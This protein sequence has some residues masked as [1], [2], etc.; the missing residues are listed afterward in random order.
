MKNMKNEKNELRQKVIAKLK[1]VISTVQVPAGDQYAMYKIEL[2]EDVANTV[3][4][5][6]VNALKDIEFCQIDTQ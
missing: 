4:G 6:V 3:F 1:E 2:S 5:A